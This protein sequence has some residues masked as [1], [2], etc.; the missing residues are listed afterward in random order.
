MNA[1]DKIKNQNLA[2]RILKGILK[3]GRIANTY[4]FT[5]LQG[6]GKKFAAIQFAKALNCPN[7]GCEQCPSCI[8]IG[9]FS[10]PD[11]HIITP[12]LNKDSILVDQMRNMQREA[13]LKP[14]IARFKVY[15]IEEAGNMTEEAANSL[16]KI[17]EEPPVDTVFIL[18]TSS[19]QDI[20]P[21]IISRCQ[22]VRFTTKSKTDLAHLPG[23]HGVEKVEKVLSLIEL[24]KIL[25]IF[26]EVKNLASNKEDAEEIVDFLALWYRDILLLKEKDEEFLIFKDRM[27][28][29]RDMEK[30]LSEDFLFQVFRDILQARHLLARN[31]SP[32][33]TLESLFLKFG[34]KNGRGYWNKT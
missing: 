6:T 28:Q 9:E 23:S 24:C 18:T 8:K 29:L 30:K 25:Q 10:H 2:S 5:G 27:E 7:G 33:L 22:M 16:L 26:R 11:V 4:L 21:T 14:F 15:I 13:Y 3:T 20:L 17:L 12:E 1:L 32:R 34:E 31:V 19:P